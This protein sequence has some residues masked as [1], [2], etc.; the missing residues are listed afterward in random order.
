MRLEP[1]P[2][3]LLDEQGEAGD[4]YFD[5]T[6]GKLMVHD[7]VTCNACWQFIILKKIKNTQDLDGLGVL[8]KALYISVMKF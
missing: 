5:A 7:G 4:M 8:F 6:S 2:V 3:P 1:Q